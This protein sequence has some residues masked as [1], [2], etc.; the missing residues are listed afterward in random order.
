MIYFLPMPRHRLFI[1]AYEGCQLLDVTGPAAVFGAANE[2]RERPV[3]DLH[4]VSPDPQ[5]HPE[6]LPNY[7]ATEHDLAEARAALLAGIGVPF[8]T[9]APSVDERALGDE[10]KHLQ[11]GLRRLAEP[12]QNTGYLLQAA[13]YA[14]GDRRYE[15]AL[16][17][18]SS[19]P[20]VRTKRVHLKPGVGTQPATAPQ[21]TPMTSDTK[22]A[23]K[24][25]VRARLRFQL[26]SS[27]PMTMPK[28]T[29]P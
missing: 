26:H 21:V 3:Y 23:M 11:A 4:I 5:R 1:L 16:K 9:A 15:A 2:G 18:I 29:Q 25:T 24:P 27:A 22:V 28:N 19:K 6:I 8:D 7:L 12:G 10:W 20:L 17:A 14:S 13:L